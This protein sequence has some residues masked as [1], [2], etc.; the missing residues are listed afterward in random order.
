M[1]KKAVIAVG[2]FVISHL[3]V[4]K[5]LCRL[6]RSNSLSFRIF[7]STCSNILLGLSRTLGNTNATSASYLEWA[8]RGIWLVS[9]RRAT[10]LY[11]FCYIASY[12]CFI[13]LMTVLK[14][15]LMR[16]FS[17]V[18]SCAWPSIFLFSINAGLSLD[19]F[20][21]PCF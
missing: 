21:P 2:C 18:R 16:G 3:A 11:V 14:V 20:S 12:S 19:Q 9:L 4:I 8:R 15:G 13:M 6:S 5:R 10:H 1:V 17:I 7:R